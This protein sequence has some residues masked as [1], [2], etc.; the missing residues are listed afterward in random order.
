MSIATRS[1]DILKN[2]YG[3]STFRRNQSE[4]IDAL[5]AGQNV[6]ALM[7]TGGGKSI[8]YQIPSILRDGIGIVIS[9]LIALMQDQVLALNE[10]GVSVRH[11]QFQCCTK[12]Y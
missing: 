6:F 9:P 7:P 2:I 12:C 4:I 3:Y 1:L 8:C 10:L 11:D 5:T